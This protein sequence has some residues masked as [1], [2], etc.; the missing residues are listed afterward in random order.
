MNSRKNKM[1]IFLFLNIVSKDSLDV[2]ELLE[3]K[4]FYMLI[5]NFNSYCA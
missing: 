2:N 4:L 1:S 3:P 5:K